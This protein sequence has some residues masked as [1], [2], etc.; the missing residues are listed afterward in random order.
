MKKLTK[1]EKED[2]KKYFIERGDPGFSPARNKATLERTIAKMDKLRAQKRKEYEEG[3]RER[4]D[5]VATYLRSRIAQGSTP[6]EKYFGK[7]WMA[8]LRGQRIKKVLKSYYN[9]A[10]GKQEPR[11]WLPN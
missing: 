3:V 6:V 9:P 5:A 7:R 2:Y 11:L 10:T 1:E 4:A 8:Y